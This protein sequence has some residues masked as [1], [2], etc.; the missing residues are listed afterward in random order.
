MNDH[1]DYLLV[2]HIA[3]DVAPDGF[4]LG[5]TVAYAAH[6]ALSFGLRVGILTSTAPNEPLLK[7]INP[8]VAIISIPAEST[9]IYENIYTPGGRIQYLRATAE[10]LMP[11]HIPQAWLHARII[12]LAPIADEVSADIADLFPHAT[13][14]TT[15]QGWMRRTDSEQRVF[16]KP[17]MDDKLM[18]R[19][20]LTVISEEDIAQAQYLEADYAAKMHR[21]VVTRGD[22][23][24]TVY[25]NGERST[26]DVFPV[27]PVDLTG[28]GDI[29]T[30]SLVCAWDRCG[31][32][33]QALNIA[34]K[35][36]AYSVKQQGSASI[37]PMDIVN[38][39][40]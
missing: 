7:Q 19:L 37:P 4:V 12:H 24:G 40:L 39:A 27:E 21:L 23:A 11:E 15:P 5:G 30:A 13:I 18:Q 6:T 26:F 32:F 10:S 25:I 17:W 28:A 34:A 22:H 29:F 33:K 9:T 38:E 3:A 20:D 2:G 8:Q 14:I 31:D 1:L 36:A 35:L 16:F